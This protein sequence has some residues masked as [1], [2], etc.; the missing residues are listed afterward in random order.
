[1]RKILFKNGLFAVVSLLFL[2]SSC[3]KDQCDLSKEIDA[4]ISFGKGLSVPVGS[5]EKVMLSDIIDVES[6]DILEV[7]AQTGDYSISVSGDFDSKA[8]DIGEMDFLIETSP[9]RKHYDFELV[10]LSEVENLPS[11]IIEEMKKQKYPFVVRNDVDYATRIDISPNIPK[12]I[13]KI[14]SLT[15]KNDVKLTINVKINSERH[16][17]DDLLELVN[18]IAFKSN[19]HNG[20]LFKVPEYL[21]FD[22]KSGIKNG[23]II[24]DGSAKYDNDSKSLI[25]TKDLHLKAFDFSHLPGGFLPVNNGVV[26]IHDELCAEGY[27]ESDTVL[28]GYNNITHIQS[29]DI[30]C[31]MSVGKISVK[32]VEGVF[33]YEMNAVDEVVELPLG[34]DLDF[35]K[36]AYFDFSDP[37]IYLTVN[38]PVDARIFA[39]A[40]LAALDANAT[41]LDGADIEVD[42]ELAGKTENKLFLNRHGN[43]ADGYT[44]VTVPNLNN[45]LKHIPEKVKLQLNA[46]VDTTRFSTF[47][48]GQ[49]YE[50]SGDYRVTLPMDFEEFNV[51]YTSTIDDL[52]GDTEDYVNGIGS[53]RLS[54]DVLN[55]IPLELT[56]EIIAYD[57]ANNPLELITVLSGGTIK[58]GNGVIYGNLTEPVV[59][60]VEI[61]LTASEDKLEALDRIDIKMTGSGYGA[62]NA[63]EYLQLKNIVLSIDEAIAI[64]L[65]SEIK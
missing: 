48:V 28:L 65:N 10:N 38:N 45:L 26:D 50:I 11:W 15:F 17:S 24:L 8:F 32:D 39:S 64:D 51:S 57:S 52:L 5:T 42:V 4:T 55:T 44:T 59:S 12:E 37:R 47:T 46:N 34:E 1:M 58:K 25:Y 60:A 30:E 20:F 53:I 36:N 23:I 22:E 7:D 31:G 27:I 54:F 19:K 63:K 9:E 62:F 33:E 21:V 29:V 61:K 18:E 16:D 49:S 43:R 56:P 2:M 3:V 13:K 14:R 41:P 40:H 6:T 35:L